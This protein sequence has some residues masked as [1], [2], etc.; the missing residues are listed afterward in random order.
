M[1]RLECESE[2]IQARAGTVPERQMGGGQPASEPAPGVQTSP[3]P[4]LTCIGTK[5]EEEEAPRGTPGLTQGLKGA[6]LSEV[7]CLT[8]QCCL[9]KPAITID[10]MFPLAAAFPTRDV[11]ES[12]LY[13]SSPDS[14]SVPIASCRT[15]TTDDVRGW[16]DQLEAAAAAEDATKA[17]L[18]STLLYQ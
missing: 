11:S 2:L 18:E 1:G 9:P 8:D 14:S 12:Q 4:S 17:L 13:T 15:K 10:A 6:F 7:A 16:G 5:E 3:N